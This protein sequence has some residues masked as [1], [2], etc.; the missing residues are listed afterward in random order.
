MHGYQ[1]S[2]P[3]VPVRA[4]GRKSVFTWRDFGGYCAVYDA[5]KFV[6]E[7]DQCSSG[8]GWYSIK[9]Q[10]IRYPLIQMQSL[11]TLQITDVGR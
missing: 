10:L 4:F 11:K 8:R 5:E 3:Y 7:N 6:L 2:V 9:W 1:Q